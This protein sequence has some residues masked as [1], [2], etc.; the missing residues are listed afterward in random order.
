M[1]DFKELCTAYFEGYIQAKLADFLLHG[2][3]LSSDLDKVKEMAVKCMEEYISRLKLTDIQKEQMK[4]NRK[5]WAELALEG[6]KQRL[7]ESGKMIELAKNTMK[8]SIVSSIY[9]VASLLYEWV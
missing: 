9:G 7:R 6:I 4:Q 8:L 2:K 5:Q 1:L 3:V